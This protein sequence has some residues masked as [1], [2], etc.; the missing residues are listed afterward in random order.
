[1][2][3]KG[4]WWECVY[5]EDEDRYTYRMQVEGGWLYRYE[6][7]FPTSNESRNACVAMV[8]VPEPQKKTKR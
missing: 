2:S 6:V 5:E 4:C 7:S 1:M 3:N 8:F